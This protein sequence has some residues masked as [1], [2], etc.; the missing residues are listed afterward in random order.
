VTPQYLKD[1][2][3][4]HQATDPGI[5]ENEEQVSTKSLAEHNIQTGKSKAKTKILKKLRRGRK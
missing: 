2:S 1:I 4:T 3:Y 5:S